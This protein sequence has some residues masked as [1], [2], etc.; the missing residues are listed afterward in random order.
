[1][2]QIHHLLGGEV[3]SNTNSAIKPVT[4]LL[5]SAEG[6]FFRLSHSNE[7]NPPSPSGCV[8]T[9]ASFFGDRKNY[10]VCT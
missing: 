8:V 1:M 10:N 4:T 7:T 5:W 2:S 6:V 3:C 9:P